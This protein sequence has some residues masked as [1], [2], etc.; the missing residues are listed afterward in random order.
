MGLLVNLGTIQIKVPPGMNRCKLSYATE[1]FLENQILIALKK[2]LKKS[3]R[4]VAYFQASLFE[5]FCKLSKQFL[6]YIT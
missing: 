5:F 4:G 3:I 1:V 2:S 6:N